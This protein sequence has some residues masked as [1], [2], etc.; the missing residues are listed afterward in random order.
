MS[1][2]FYLVGYQVNTV[3]S[4]QHGVNTGFSCVKT[5]NLLV[6]CQLCSWRHRAFPVSGLSSINSLWRRLAEA[7]RQQ[8]SLTY[9][10]QWWTISLFDSRAV[11]LFLRPFQHSNVSS[12]CSVS[13]PWLAEVGGVSWQ[14]RHWKRQFH[15][16][17]VLSRS[18]DIMLRTGLFKPQLVVTWAVYFGYCTKTLRSNL[19][20]NQRIIWSEPPSRGMAHWVH[21]TS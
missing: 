2:I 15:W 7:R 5:Y 19:N 16:I 11:I 21:T 8:F 10:F 13:N 9:Y 17:V 14:F 12:V 20:G 6:Q 1:F 3:I 18:F 4:L